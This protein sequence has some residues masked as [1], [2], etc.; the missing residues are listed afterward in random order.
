MLNRIARILVIAAGIVALLPALAIAQTDDAPQSGY[1]DV[2]DLH[3]YY[4]IHGEATD[5]P[6]L[7]ML[8]GAYM[9]IDFMG[10]ILP[11][12]AETRQ[13]IAVELQGHGRTNDIDRPITYEDMADDVFALIQE[14]GLESVD[15]VG[16]SM[17]GD[18][19]LQIAIRHPEVVNKLIVISASYQLDGLYPDLIDSISMMMPEVFAGSPIETEYQ[20]LSPNPEAFATLVEKLVALDG[21]DFDWSADVAAIEVPTLIIMGDNDAVTLQH[22]IDMYGLL[23]GGVMGDLHGLPDSQLAIIPGATHTAILLRVNLLTPI[24]TD[25]LD[26]ITYSLF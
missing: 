9:N 26:G 24:I 21:T 16:Y 8:H 4:E 18:T 11:S 25:F 12:L 5:A 3:M 2:N 7:V 22:M 1:V 20:R 10:E 13:V 19:A 14:L 6:P 15:V 17:G 23:G